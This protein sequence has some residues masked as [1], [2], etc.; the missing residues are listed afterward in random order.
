MLDHPTDPVRRPKMWW[1]TCPSNWN[2]TNNNICL[3]FK[4][5]PV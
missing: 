3:S 5:C 4:Y 1:K 2:L